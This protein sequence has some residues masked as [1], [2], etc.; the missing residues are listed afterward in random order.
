MLQDLHDKV[1][2]KKQE[3]DNPINIT[4]VHWECPEKVAEP[5]PKEE[6]EAP[7]APNTS[8]LLKSLK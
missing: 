8:Q 1:E 2:V 7:I 4:N 3:C 5:V 6:E